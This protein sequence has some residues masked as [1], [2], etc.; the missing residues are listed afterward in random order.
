MQTIL[1]VMGSLV[2]S[3]IL[4]IVPL[5]MMDRNQPQ[6]EATEEQN[7]D[8][9]CNEKDETELVFADEPLEEMNVNSFFTY[10]IVDELISVALAK[11]IVSKEVSAEFAF[12]IN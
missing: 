4:W 6:E 2:T 8:E 3:S 11:K 10:S 12:S 7:E 9:D 1:I 5:L